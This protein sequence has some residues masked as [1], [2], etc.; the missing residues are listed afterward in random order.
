M[1]IAAGS[2]LAVLPGRWQLIVPV[3]VELADKADLR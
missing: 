1:R 2:I 3:R